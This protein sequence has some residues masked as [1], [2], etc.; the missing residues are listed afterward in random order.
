M[1][2]P[3]SR[4]SSIE[5]STCSA[6]SRSAS[7]PHI[8]MKRSASVD[9]PWSI[10]AMMEKFRMWLWS[11][12]NE[13]GC[14]LWGHPPRGGILLD[15][16]EH[17]R[18]ESPVAEL[19]AGGVG[20]HRHPITVDCSQGSVGVDVELLERDAEGAQGARHQLAEVAAGAAVEPSLCQSTPRWG[21]TPSAR[22]ASPA[23]S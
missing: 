6:I 18:V 14:R 8:W 15:S 22:R 1:V 7:P 11:I 5:S 13:R 3:R 17:R 10:W 2:M 21:R 20:E 12:Y 16:L 23:A 19:V 9:L 4:S